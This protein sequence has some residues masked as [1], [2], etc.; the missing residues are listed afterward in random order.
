MLWLPI[1]RAMNT[2]MDENAKKFL[3]IC[4]G[5]NVRSQAMVVAL[6]ELH[7]QE[8]I[9][10]GRWRVSPL[11]MEML[12]SWA[13][14]IIVMQPHMVESVPAQFHG[15]TVCVDVGE[16]R[17]GI[18]VHPELWVMVQSGAVQVLNG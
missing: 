4:D 10:I 13:D 17:F 12:C 7:R 2:L 11:T 16:D 8:A 15:K 3:C 18:Q 1:T 14:K 5:G 6:K 9:A